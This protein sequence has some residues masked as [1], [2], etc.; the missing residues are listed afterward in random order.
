MDLKKKC[1]ILSMTKEWF[2]RTFYYGRT[3]RE[4]RTL[5]QVNVLTVLFGAK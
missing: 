2:L 5:A 4:N 1:Y 3:G